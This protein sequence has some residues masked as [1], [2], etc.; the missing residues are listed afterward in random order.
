MKIM[1]NGEKKMIAD[2]AT[3]KKM[4]GEIFKSETGH[5]AVAVNLNFV[6]RSEYEAFAL[7]EGDDVEVVS[8][9]AGG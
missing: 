3:I 1:V 7:K 4:L 9:Q 6:P 8:P 2:G 5:M